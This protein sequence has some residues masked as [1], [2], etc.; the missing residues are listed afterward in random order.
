MVLCFSHVLQPQK[1]TFYLQFTFSILSQSEIEFTQTM[2]TRGLIK[3]RKNG[4][5]CSVFGHR[6]A[7]I[8]TWNRKQRKNLYRRCKRQDDF[9]S[10]SLIKEEVALNRSRH[11]A[12]MSRITDT[13]VFGHQVKSIVS[14][15]FG[16][17]RR[18]RLY[19]KLKSRGHNDVYMGLRELV[20]ER[21]RTGRIRSVLRIRPSAIE[22]GFTALSIGSG[23]MEIDWEDARRYKAMKVQQK[24]KKSIKI[25]KSNVLIF[26]FRTA[27]P[28]VR[29][30]ILT[31]SLRTL[32]VRLSNTSSSTRN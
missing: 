4:L 13:V 9:D 7:D 26:C 28:L 19:R 23:N 2:P 10:L 30:S 15:E 29:Q 1:K 25:K 27:V 5:D 17:R 32:W 21:C 24:M 18:S 11:E 20:D 14:V 16:G 3:R 31:P 6:L 8:V 12:K 22:D